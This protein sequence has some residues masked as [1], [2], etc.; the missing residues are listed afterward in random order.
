MHTLCLC[1]LACVCS[2]SACVCTRVC[3][4]SHVCAL[5]SACVFPAPAVSFWDIPELVAADPTGAAEH[6]EQTGLSSNAKAVASEA[7]SQPAHAR[8]GVAGGHLSRRRHENVAPLSVHEADIGRALKA[9]QGK[10][11]DASALDR[12]G[13]R[14]TPRPG[15]ESLWP[16]GGLGGGWRGRLGSSAFLRHCSPRPR[17]GSAAAGGAPRS[18]AH[19]APLREHRWRLRPSSCLPPPLLPA[20]VG[21]PSEVQGTAPASRT[22]PPLCSGPGMHACLA[23]HP[24]QHPGPVPG[25]APGLA[26]GP[27]PG[28]A[29]GLAPRRPLRRSPF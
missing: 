4:R 28:P 8:E 23:Q 13:D 6:R 20:V 1:V 19:R 16:S 24:G 15:G 25:P 3:V 7:P 29:P 26:P 14:Q 2:V 12:N 11:N 10:T 17:A 5:V 21:S 9:A 22:S 27:A 18:C